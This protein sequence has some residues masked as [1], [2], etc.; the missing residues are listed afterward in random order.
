MSSLSIK[1]T[2]TSFGNLI[3][4][5]AGIGKLHPSLSQLPKCHY[6][7]PPR[8]INQ[9]YIEFRH[10]F[11]HIAHK[12]TP[13]SINLSQEANTQIQTNHHG[14]DNFHFKQSMQCNVIHFQ[15]YALSMKVS[16]Y[17]RGQWATPKIRSDH[18]KLHWH[19][20]T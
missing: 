12:K 10:L 16:S 1:L 18:E 17:Y 5:E 4:L 3:K 20:I 2:K 6:F 14:R 9:N 8:N 15:D 19:C 13:H 11:A 7:S